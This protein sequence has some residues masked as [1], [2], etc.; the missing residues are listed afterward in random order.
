MLS[1][2]SN[3][4]FE[5]SANSV[6]FIRKTWRLAALNARP[7][8]SGVRRLSYFLLLLKRKVDIF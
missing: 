8:N 4:S 3:D 6:A 2:L 1:T 5:R 7:L